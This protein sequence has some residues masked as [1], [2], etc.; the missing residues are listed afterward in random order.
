MRGSPVILQE[1]GRLRRH[2]A[3]EGLLERGAADG[4][5]AV[6]H[7]EAVS[8]IWTVIEHQ[9]DRREGKHGQSLQGQDDLCLGVGDCV[10]EHLGGVE[11]CICFVASVYPLAA[12]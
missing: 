12:L 11:E 10:G 9:D 3:G 7:G 4:N 5:D 8:R 2:E 1:L 6:E